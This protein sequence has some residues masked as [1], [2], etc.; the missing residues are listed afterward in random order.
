MF[1]S[2]FLGGGGIFV[3]VANVEIQTNALFTWGWV[4][5]VEVS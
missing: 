4:G 5:R 2:V 3:G 1:Q